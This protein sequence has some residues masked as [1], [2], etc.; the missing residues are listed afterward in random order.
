MSELVLINPRRKRRRKSA[1]RRKGRMPPALAAY[2]AGKRSGG[3]RRRRRKLRAP[4]RARARRRRAVGYT[5]GTRKIRRR[6]LNPRRHVS[7][8]RRHRS[9]GGFR[10]RR[11]KRNP[12]FGLPSVNGIVKGTI[13]PAAIGATGAIA[14]DV[15]YGYASPYLPAFL[16]SKWASL[17]VKLAGAIGIGMVAGKVLGRER[18]RVATLGAATVVAYGALKSSLA[19]A[20]PTV[21][22]LSG[23]ADFVD[24]SSYSRAPGMGFYSPAATIAPSGVGAYLPRSGVGAYMAQ[25][26]SGA[27]GMGGY[28]WSNDGM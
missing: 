2:W 11:R 20:L 28:D 7:R 10:M 14:L 5:V 25:N 27:E 3:K 22:G 16:Q 26:L 1:R 21:P 23:Y 13:M 15:A 17:A 19:T 18:G 4:R 8:R 24:Y 9:F 12:R 6:K